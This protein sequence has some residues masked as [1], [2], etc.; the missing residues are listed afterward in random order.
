MAKVNRPHSEIG[1][2]YNDSIRMTCCLEL[3]LEF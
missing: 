3:N 1:V 2:S